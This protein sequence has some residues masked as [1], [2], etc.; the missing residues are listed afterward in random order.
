MRIVIID[1]EL[2][3]RNPRWATEG[4]EYAL[5]VYAKHGLVE[6][7]SME[8]HTVKVTGELSDEAFTAFANDIGLGDETAE[9][10]LGALTGYGHVTGD[11]YG[12][13]GMGWNVGGVTP[14]A[15][16]GVFVSDPLY[17]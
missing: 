11:S 14:F 12:I 4:K 17:S 16:V 5:N 1:F 8:E 7:G 13:D 3:T 10:N 2:E 9:P 6:S 15:Y